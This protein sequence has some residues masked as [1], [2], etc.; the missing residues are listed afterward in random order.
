MTHGASWKK[1]AVI[2]TL[3]FPLGAS[4]GESDPTAATAAPQAATANSPVSA[5]DATTSLPLPSNAPLAASPQDPKFAPPLPPPGPFSAPPLPMQQAYS[6]AAN[7]APALGT[8]PTEESKEQQRNF[9]EVLDDVLGD[10]EFDLKNGNVVG[11]AEIALRNISV[12]EN[13][14]ESFKSHLEPLITERILKTTKTRMLQCLPCKARKTSLRGDQVVISSPQN[15]QE[16]LSRIAHMAGISHFLDL[17]FLYQPSGIVLSFYITD[18]DSGSVIWSRTYNSETSRASA[19]RRG[20]DYS[21][22]DQARSKTEY[23]PTLQGRVILSFISEPSLPSKQN[24]L[25]LG[26]RLVERYDNRKKEIGFEANYKTDATTIVSSANQSSLGLYNFKSINLTLLFL[27]T[28]NF[29][30]EEENYNAV[31]TA[32]T[33]GVGGTYASGFLGGLVRGS[34]EFRLAK[35]YALSLLVGYRPPAEAFVGTTSSGTVQGLA[36]GAGVN[37]LF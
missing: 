25:G 14:P 15:S 18:A 11:L 2:L 32:F 33:L 16:E 7:D 26:Y 23:S 4:S 27:H 3:S 1:A 24:C 10:F 17:A 12:S 13:V 20:V 34:F 6:T 36:L 29:I 31:R 28:W 22:I 9:Y 8:P 19:F 5:P 35:H 21:Q 30:G 37:Y